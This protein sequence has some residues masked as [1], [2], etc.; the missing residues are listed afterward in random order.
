MYV[1]IDYII[2]L[3]NT[4]LN[5]VPE[6]ASLRSSRASR[7]NGGWS[8]LLHEESNLNDVTEEMALRFRNITGVVPSEDRLKFERMIFRGTRGNCYTHC[9]AI[10]DPITDPSSGTLVS[11]HAFV[12]FYQSEFIENKLRK[13][14]DAFHAR[15]YTLPDVDDSQALAQLQQSNNVELNQSSHILRRN[16]ESCIALCRQLSEHLQGWKWTVMQ[17]KATYH[18]LNLLKSDVCG[19]LRGEGW[20]IRSALEDVRYQVTKAHSSS[21]KSMPSLVDHVTGV[22]PTPPTFFET[23]KFTDSF[24]NFVDTY[25]VPRY[26]EIN[27]AVFTA[28]T[29]PFLFGIMY[30]DMVR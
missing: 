17:E 10:E 26:R 2:T 5:I 27:P 18:T 21:D 1:P 29:F 14:C 20:V 19:M 12:I 7:M 16:R 3:T 13:I 28:V 4:E 11:K 15:L 8:P 22:W 6:A 9:S 25:G 30:G 24:Q 23:N